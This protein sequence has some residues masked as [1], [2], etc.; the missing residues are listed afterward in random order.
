[1]FPYFCCNNILYQIFLSCD[2]VCFQINQYIFLLQRHLKR[3]E[4][5][6]SQNQHYS[7]FFFLFFFSFLIFPFYHFKLKAT[8]S[9]DCWSNCRTKSYLSLHPPSKNGVNVLGNLLE[10]ILKHKTFLT[11]VWEPQN[12]THMK[13]CIPFKDVFIK[14]FKYSELPPSYFLYKKGNGH[15]ILVN[16]ISVFTGFR[17]LCTS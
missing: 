5:N 14:F 17:F 2:T 13:S 12:C 10:L 11:F 9:E 7:K 1:M 3:R 6:A 15:L 4:K 16:T 8:G